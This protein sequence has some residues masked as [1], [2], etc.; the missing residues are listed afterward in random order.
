MPRFCIIT[1][2]NQFTFEGIQNKNIGF[3]LNYTF[4]NLAFFSE[5]SRTISAGGAYVGGILWS[6][7][8]KLD[9]SVLYRKFDRNFYSFYSNAFA[10]NSITQNESGIYWGYKYRF[11]QKISLAG[12]VDLFQFPWLRYRGYTPSAGHEWLL[13]FTYQPSRKV[14][15]FIQGR[16]ESKSRN[17]ADE[18]FTLYYT[19]Q[20]KK[21]NYW[22]NGDYGLR[23]KLRMKT[24]AQFSTYE[25]NNR[26]TNGFALMQ[27]ISVEVGKFQFTFRYALFDTDDYDNRQYVYEND[28]LLAYSMPAY[29]GIGVRKIAMMEYKMNRY[30][31]FWLRYATMRYPYDEKIGSGIDTIEGNIKNDVKFQIRITF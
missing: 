5:V 12:Y 22:I 26:I 18:N 1:V 8:P 20:G 13:R 9:V 23:Q 15:I 29:D 24:R 17:I 10:E 28:V 11:N 19:G 21:H 2:Y 14:M 7:T 3:F 30:V 16:E 31:S 27:D 25:F 4:Q 6:L